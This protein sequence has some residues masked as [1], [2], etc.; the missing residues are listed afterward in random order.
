MKIIQYGKENSKTVVLI[1]P[2][3]AADDY[4]DKVIP[5][6]SG[7]YHIVV[8]M[9]TDHDDGDAEGEFHSIAETAVLIELWLANRGYPEVRCVYGS[10]VGA[11][12]ALHMLSDG[13]IRIYSAVTDGRLAPETL[14][15][16]LVT[17]R[18]IISSPSAVISGLRGKDERHDGRSIRNI[19]NTSRA[20]GGQE[21]KDETCYSSAKVIYM[22]SEED[23][24]R[25]IKD[26]RY[27]KQQFPGV[28]FMRLG[29]SSDP[30]L[31]EPRRLASV[32]E[33]ACSSASYPT[34]KGS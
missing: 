28:R 29:N 17:A 23:K 3:Y 24:S 27:L 10:S 12:A 11:A 34:K 30:A 26:I 16:P 9:L 14:P 19:R 33:R 1:R 32:I 21:I 18:D 13:R 15:A 2:L 31:E 5:Y 22:F 4:F 7:K 20:L 25:R 8:P 6:L